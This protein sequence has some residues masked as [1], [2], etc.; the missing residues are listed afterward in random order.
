MWQL[1]IRN[2]L[3]YVIGVSDFLILIQSLR[4]IIRQSI[5]IMVNI[6]VCIAAQNVNTM[7]KLC[8]VYGVHLINK[9]W[10]D[11]LWVIEK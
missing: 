9:F 1:R 10:R 8:V 3:F 5:S 11:I 2:T 6:F 4:V 7:K